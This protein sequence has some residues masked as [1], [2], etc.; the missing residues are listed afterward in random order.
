MVVTGDGSATTHDLPERRLLIDIKIMYAVT[1][2]TNRVVHV[3]DKITAERGISHEQFYEEF[4]REIP[5]KRFAEPSEIAVM[6]AWLAS[7]LASYITGQN[8]NVD[9]G[10]ARGLV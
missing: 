9:G 7:P 8:I 10:I 2:V 6:I 3:L 5:L 4:S 1:V